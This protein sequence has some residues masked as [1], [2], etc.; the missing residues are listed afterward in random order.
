MQ[1]DTRGSTAP[2]LSGEARRQT[3]TISLATFNAP[4][5][6]ELAGMRATYRPNPRT[7]G[8]IT[9]TAPAR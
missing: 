2:L 9:P 7:F 4:A 6:F 5:I 1:T 3:G 8:Q